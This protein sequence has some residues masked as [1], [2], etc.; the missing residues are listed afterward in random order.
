MGAIRKDYK[1]KWS[2]SIDLFT[3]IYKCFGN[4]NDGQTAAERAAE[5]AKKAQAAAKRAAAKRAGRAAA[6]KDSDDLDAAG[7]PKTTKENWTRG[8]KDQLLFEKLVK[9]WAK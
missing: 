7:A 1:T 3:A 5:A 8:N 6:K 2:N 9:K 4:D